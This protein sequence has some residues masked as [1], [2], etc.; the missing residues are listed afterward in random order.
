VVVTTTYV[1][2]YT[3][4]GYN[5]DSATQT[6]ACQDQKVDSAIE[7]TGT[8]LTNKVS[9]LTVMATIKSRPLTAR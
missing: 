7:E 5:Y 9:S 8:S 3:E 4:L 6:Q 2:M 1:Y